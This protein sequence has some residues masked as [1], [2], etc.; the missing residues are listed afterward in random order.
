M[1]EVTLAI[2]LASASLAFAKET[3]LVFVEVVYAVVVVIME[4]VFIFCYRVI[5]VLRAVEAVDFF[6]VVVVLIDGCSFCLVFA[7]ILI[8]SIEALSFPV[9]VQSNKLISKS[10]I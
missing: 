3:P 1:E 8:D 6:T 7:M 2:S 5:A 9:E 10:E 4:A